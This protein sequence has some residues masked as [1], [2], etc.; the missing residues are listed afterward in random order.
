MCSTLDSFNRVF[1]SFIYIGL[2]VRYSIR[3]S[4][5]RHIMSREVLAGSFLFGHRPAGLVLARVY[6]VCVRTS[7]GW[8]C[9]CSWHGHRPTGFAI[10]LVQLVCVRTSSGRYCACAC[11]CT[12]TACSY[13]D[14]VQPVVFLFV[15]V[16]LFLFLLQ[17]HD[18]AVAAHA[19]LKL[20][21]ELEG[22]SSHFSFKR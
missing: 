5:L 11:S 13:S 20:K 12:R 15:F 6:I 10:V 16:C 1:I 9:A 17:A 3:A 4:S 22:A 19:K 18:P 2:G 7:S 8:S 21:A 14:I